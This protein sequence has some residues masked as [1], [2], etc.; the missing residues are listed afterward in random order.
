MLLLRKLSVSKKAEY[1]NALIIFT[2]EP[3]PGMT[4]TRLMPEFTPE[5]CAEFHKCFLRDISKEMKKADADIFVAY[6]GG[7]PAFLKKTFRRAFKEGRTFEQNGTDLGERMENAFRHVLG[8][9]YDKAVLIGTDIPEIGAETI[10]AAFDSL[11]GSDIVM[12][13]TADGGYYLIGMKEARHEAFDVRLYGIGTVFDETME[14]VRSAGLSASQVRAYSDIDDPDDLARL[15]ERMVYDK[16][17][18]CSQTGRALT[19]NAVISVIIPVYN[20]AGIIDSMTD[21]LKRCCDDAEF[22]FVDGGSTDGTLEK[23]ER[24]ADE[25]ER[26]GIRFRMIRSEKGR[27]VQMNRGAVESSGDILF[28]LHCDCRLPEDFISE[29]R[30]CMAEHPYGCFG[31]SYDSHNFFMLTNRIISNHRAWSRGIPFGDQGIF[32]DRKLFFDMGMYP[33]IP[34]MEDYEF[35][36]RMKAAGY[37]PVGTR[38]RMIGSSRRYGSSTAG[39]LRTEAI[40]W[41]LR[42]QYRKGVD[43]GKLSEL[44]KDVR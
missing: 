36:L 19:R 7:E 22:I 24:A 16:G 33:E 21:Q 10:E 12:G 30:A 4:K 3:V 26:A 5:Q 2:R 18:R 34:L 20:E 39:I 29:I 40:M 38:Q 25:A 41:C 42:R 9:G 35:S 43:P 1:R 13:P 27:G 17:L 14:S 15:R 8:L 28:F 31:L 44:Y 23:L 6:T 32:M 11:D 37:R